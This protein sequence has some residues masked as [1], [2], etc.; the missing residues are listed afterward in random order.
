[1][2]TYRAEFFTA[3]DYAVRDFAADTPEEAL[4][5]AR[6]FYDEDCGALDF[7]SYDDNAGIDQIQ[8]WDNERGTVASWESDDCRL[9]Q[10]SSELLK[11]S[12]RVLA[13]LPHYGIYNEWGM[14][15]L[16]AAIFQ[17]LRIEHDQ[18]DAKGFEDAIANAKK[19]ESSCL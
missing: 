15:E 11:Q 1:M 18:Y 16:R 8:I 3:A 2:Q 4:Q 6:R 7:R 13:M 9:R 12:I 14:P 17:A 10:S 19:G 5:L